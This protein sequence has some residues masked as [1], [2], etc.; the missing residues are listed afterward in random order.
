MNIPLDM[1]FYLLFVVI[2]IILIILG[3][4]LHI[5]STNAFLKS[6]ANKYLFFVL[7]LI[8][9]WSSVIYWIFGSC[10][11]KFYSTIVIFLT[12]LFSNAFLCFTAFKW[13]NDD[14][15]IKNMV[16]DNFKLNTILG[17]LLGLIPLFFS[18][19]LS[20]I[21]IEFIKSLFL[22]LILEI[23]F[24]P[25][26]YVIAV[27]N[28]YINAYNLYSGS[29]FNVFKKCTLNLRC[30]HRFNVQLNYKIPINQEIKILDSKESEFELKSNNIYMVGNLIGRFECHVEI[31]KIAGKMSEAHTIR[32]NIYYIV[33]DN[34]LENQDENMAFVY[35]KYYDINVKL[36][37]EIEYYPMQIWSPLIEDIYEFKLL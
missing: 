18:F 4:L 33:G 25:I 16:M 32:K 14:S 2:I 19:N 6:L 11:T 34:E 20:L 28:E 26:I 30:I 27:L 23:L 3:L 12:I 8:I 24:L 37:V 13:A 7:I 9:L 17:V 15:F 36:F 10:L 5:K 1:I 22:P 21:V 29:I 35:F 31:P